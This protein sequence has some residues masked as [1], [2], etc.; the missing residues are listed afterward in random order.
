MRAWCVVGVVGLAGVCAAQQQLDKLV[1]AEG[2]A[3]DSLGIGVGVDGLTCVAGALASDLAVGEGG[4]AYVFVSEDGQSWTQAAALTPSTPDPGAQYGRSV[5]V[6][7][8]VVMVGATQDD[9]AAT[10]GGAVYVY[11]RD[12]G[13]PGAWG[14]VQRLIPDDVDELDQFGFDVDIEGDW[15]IVGSPGD[16]DAGGNAGAAYL[17]RRL[18]DGTWSQEQKL[19]P[20]E[21]SALADAGW[22]V[23]IDGDTAVVGAR[24]D[25]SGASN[26]G[27]A[28]VYRL[29]GD[30]WEPVT[31][32]YSDD[33]EPSDWFGESVAVSG[34][35]IVV[36]ARNE[37]E[38]GGS[39]GAAYVFE[40]DA[41]GP[42]AWGQTAKLLAD[43]G[44]GGDLFG[45]SVA[46]EGD[47]VLVGAP[48]AANDRGRLY[49][50]RRD[51]AAWTSGASFAGEERQRLIK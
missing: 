39:A 14:E 7:G 8:D 32:L 30:A 19:V 41:G 31:K 6:A 51:G 38:L 1:A 44:I 43:D 10:L 36:G 21:I 20:G 27:S 49:E 18:G 42:E 45:E 22:S 4:A 50:F 13:G 5:A 33:L 37:D 34:D 47:R 17:F 16:D 40:R 3:G 24:R 2:M 23:A 26:A 35:V 15:A 46:V 29:V 28:F 12:E 11:E 25:D 48:N 9:A